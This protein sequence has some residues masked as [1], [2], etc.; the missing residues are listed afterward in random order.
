MKKY[1]TLPVDYT[2]L[3]SEIQTYLQSTILP[4][5]EY[6][7]LGKKQL[8]ESGWNDFASQVPS[9]NT[10]FADI[11]LVVEGCGYR[12]IQQHTWVRPNVFT[13]SVLMIPLTNEPCMITLYEPTITAVKEQ[14][15]FY[16]LLSCTEAESLLLGQQL[17]IGPEVSHRIRPVATPNKTPFL[18]IVFTAPGA[19]EFL[20]D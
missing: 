1:A 8:S 4:D 14:L 13:E 19:D 2:S 5:L 3:I 20:I 16:P 17:L 12:E 9:I 10:I 11:G 7:W 15:W 18:M 6:V